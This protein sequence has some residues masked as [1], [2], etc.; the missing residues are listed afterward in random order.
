LFQ[1]DSLKEYLE[2][3]SSINVQSFISAEWNLNLA[4]NIKQIGNYRFRPLDDV[5]SLY[6]TPASN[7]DPSDG[8]YFYTDATNSDIF[9]DGGFIDPETPDYFVSSKQKEEILFSLEDC[10]KRFRPRSGI[11][12]ARFFGNNFL[13]HTN[14]FM[15]NRPRYY[16]SDKNDEF[17][18]WS[19]YRTSIVYEYEYGDGTTQYGD[20]PEFTD[21]NVVYS[22]TPY[23]VV[24]RGI[25]NRPVF[26]SFFIDDAAPFIVYKK[27][28]PA[29]R[30]VVK[31]QT[32][33]GSTDLGPFYSNAG[34]F[35]DPLFGDQNKAVPA[36][37]KIQVLKNNA[38]IDAVEFDANSLRADGTSIIK[39]DGYV[40]IYY[41]NGSWQLFDENISSENGFV[42][43]LVNPSYTVNQVTGENIYDEIEYISGVRLLVKSMSKQDSVFDLIEIS[44]RLVANITDMV[45]DYNITKS[46]SDL[47]ISGLPVGQLLASTGSL[48][49]FDTQLAFFSLNENSIISDFY[50]QNIQLKFYEIISNSNESLYVPIKTMYTEE[51][52]ETSLSD[53]TT[54]ISLRDMFFYLESIAAPELLIEQASLSYAVSSILDYIGFSN[55]SFRRVDGESDPIIPFFFVSPDKTV[56]Q[57]L[58]DLAVSTQTAMFFD[59]YNNFICMSKRYIMPSDSERLTDVVLYGTKDQKKTDIITNDSTSQSLSNIIEIASKDN[60]VFNDGK[61]LYSTKYIQKTYGSLRQANLVDREK[62]WIYKPV[63]LWEVSPSES[64]KSINDELSDQSKYVLGAIPLNS[65]LSD[66]VPS[67]IG[68]TVVDNVIDFGEGVYWITRYNGYFY[69]NGE[70]IKYDAVEYTIPGFVDG[71]GGS[72][73]WI[74]SVKEYQRYFSQI[75]FNGK[76]F[77]TGRVRIYT[78]PN[79]E[80]VSGI[81]RLA[82]GPVAKHGRGQFGTVPVDHFAGL[83]SY[84][85]DNEN[86]AGC[87]MRS[88]FLFRPNSVSLDTISQST[89]IAAGKGSNSSNDLVAR[90]TP[91]NGIIRNFLSSSYY[92]ENEISRKYSTQTGTIQSSALIMTGQSIGAYS[93]IDFLTYIHKPLNNRFTHFGT[94]MRI[95]GKV[96]DQSFSSSQS[97]SGSV[98]YYTTSGSSPDQNI[99]VGAASGGLAVLLNPETN[100]GYYF[101]IAALTDNSVDKYVSAENVHNMYFYKIVADSATAEAIPVKLW[102][103][104]ANIV[105]DSGDF[106]GQYRLAGEDNPTVYDLAVEYQDIGNIRRF[107]LYV[108]NKQVATVDDASPIANIQHNM[109]VFIRGS[110][111]CMFENVYALTNNYS[112]SMK[113]IDE[114]PVSSAFKLGEVNQSEGYRKYA[115][116]GAISDT[117]LSTLSPQNPP[118]HSIYYDEFGTIMREVAYFNVRYDKA[119]PA[120]YAEMSPT[121]N[122]LKGYSVSGF[123]AGSYGAEFLI[124]NTSDTALNLDETS[125]NYLRIQG[126]TF[127]Q[128]SDNELTVD[129][130]YNKYGDLSNT[131]FTFDP[132]VRPSNV[133]REEYED[134]RISRITYGKKEFSIEAPYI[135]SHDEAVD[136][137][138]W[139]MPKISKPRLSVGVSI[140]ANPA[141]QLGDI[142]SI[143]YSDNNNV[144]QIS[145][146]DK[147]FVVYNIEYSR[148]P[149]G[150]NMKIYLSEVL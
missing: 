126:V 106:A 46:A 67:V 11:N 83:N 116:S 25:A 127:T 109:A 42:T 90:R 94:R 32:H 5:G 122:K 112:V 107:F 58:Q 10:F 124:F 145:P 133:V 56:A 35:S 36:D 150:P 114:A 142:V 108:N 63:L 82:N 74:S 57:I 22:G 69:S 6:K 131:S 132:T 55:Y 119:Y 30:L 50:N 101:E 49:V 18:Y 110:S 113:A 111:K 149:E 88:E 8:G 97:P 146:S 95:V 93:P 2:T 7:F 53:R 120:L 76:M 89:V 66:R 80:T 129:D 71:S 44:P 51:F 138:S 39:E 41:S 77:P 54:S 130:F 38:W 139:I 140:L 72:N 104:L 68:N 15:A 144:L 86:V 23:E 40:E 117:Y 79:Y 1:S 99:S 24:E 75:P 103:G 27:P 52:P 9:I 134:V 21:N 81:T 123:R 64:T 85:T 137:M 4:E 26:S 147:R 43:E 121:F 12:K 48:T 100:V 14:S 102:G 70:I 59:E 135:Q 105:V 29:N 115:I 60:S 87:L 141:I 47:G 148:S 45:L 92:S 96:K 37:W 16:M 136:L 34:T 28:V 125:G 118:E 84:W 33:V 20:N 78:E 65:D 73:F 19:S 143:D 31:M 61:I 62:S 128:N 13:H 17:K 98:T 91:R 3:S